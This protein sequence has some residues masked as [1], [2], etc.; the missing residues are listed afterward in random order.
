MKSIVIAFTTT[1][2]LFTTAQAFA[3]ERTV[4]LQ[5]QGMMAGCG[6]IV[7]ETLA[8][9]EGVRKVE[10]VY[11]QETAVVAFE[12]TTTDVATLRAATSKVGYPFTVIE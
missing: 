11:A 7:M 4:N 3:A 12:D 6:Y 5:F 2:A 10:V 9:V 8:A 1:I